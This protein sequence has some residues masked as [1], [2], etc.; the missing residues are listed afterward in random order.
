MVLIVAVLSPAFA[1]V[2]Q[3]ADDPG[4][5][6]VGVRAVG[7][8]DHG[9]D[10]RGAAPLDAPSG[11]QQTADR[12]EG[13]L[14]LLLQARGGVRESFLADLA[15]L[16]LEVLVLA[17][18]QAQGAFADLG[19]AGGGDRRRIEQGLERAVLARGESRRFPLFSLLAVL[20]GLGLCTR[21]ILYKPPF[22]GFCRS[23][24]AASPPRRS[25]AWDRTL[26]GLPAPKCG[27]RLSGVFTPAVR[28][29]AMGTPLQSRL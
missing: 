27:D 8:I 20:S 1:V 22:S 4:E 29:G 2:F 11:S 21:I 26:S 23:F 25:S 24:E 9:A 12:I 5:I 16:G 6:A 10:E 15:Q 3:R 14:G 18:P 19:L 28:I 7:E 17:Q 13:A